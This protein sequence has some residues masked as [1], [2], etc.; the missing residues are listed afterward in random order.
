MMPRNYRATRGLVVCGAIVLFVGMVFAGA[1]LGATPTSTVTPTI[2]RGTATPTRG[3]A[4]A[5]TPGAI[6]VAAYIPTWTNL[7]LRSTTTAPLISQQEAQQVIADAG[8][9]WAF[10]G[11]VAGKTVTVDAVHGLGTIGQ[12]GSTDKLALPDGSH[13]TGAC[14]G[15]LGICNY[16]VKKCI[17]GTC[18]ATGQVIDR[19]QDRPMWVIH[20]ANLTGYTSGGTTNHGVVVIDDATRSQVMSW[21]YT[22]P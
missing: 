17:N 3:P 11:Q 5:A 12:P 13:P 9:S 20:Y 16:P 14:Q 10:G 21:N 8:V 22:G 4:V 18:T 6:I 1:A 2:G 7:V 15:W 19:F